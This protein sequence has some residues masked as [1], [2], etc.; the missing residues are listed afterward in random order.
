MPGPEQIQ[1][2]IQ[3]LR[4]VESDQIMGER[5]QKQPLGVEVL[6]NPLVRGKEFH[7]TLR[8]ACEE[9]QDGTFPDR[10]QRQLLPQL[11]RQDRVPDP[12]VL[13]YGNQGGPIGN[14]QR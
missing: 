6:W 11:L 5:E 2:F 4:L 10:Q 14:Q 7:H 8:L 13:G 1:V 9:R 12:S 3:A